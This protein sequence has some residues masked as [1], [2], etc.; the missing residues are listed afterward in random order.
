MLG[1]LNNNLSNLSGRYLWRIFFLSLIAVTLL[2]IIANLWVSWQWLNQPFAGFLQQNQ[3]ITV[4]RLPGWPAWEKGIETGD[5]ILKVE[6]QPLPTPFFSSLD[7]L[8]HHDPSQTVTYLLQKTDGRELEVELGPVLFTMQ[9][10]AQWVFIPTFMALIALTSSG[11]LGYVMPGRPPVTLFGLLTLATIYATISLP[12]LALTQATFYINFF[13]GRIGGILTP[14][15]LLHFLLCYPFTRKKLQTWPFLLPLIYL[16]VLPSFIHLFVLLDQ[17]EAWPTFEKIRTLYTA[18]YLLSGVG[19]LSHAVSVGSS[20]IRKRAIVLLIGLMLPLTLFLLNGLEIL[21]AFTPIYEMAERY[22]LW[23][24]PITVALALFRYDF[25]QKERVSHKHVLFTATLGGLLAICL[26]LF[27]WTGPIPIGFKR[28]QGQDYGFILITVG[29]FYMGRLAF[30][31]FR[32][33]WASRH[34]RYSVEDFR[35]NVRIL[36]RELLKVKSHHELEALISW[37]LATDFSLQSAEISTRN[38]PS[39]P[40]ALRLPLKVNNVSLG[41]LFLGSKINGEPFSKQEQNIFGEA[42]KQI[43]LTLLSLEL[44]EVIQ[45]TEKLT[46]LK[47][48]FLTNVTHELRTPLNGIIN[49]IGFALD[50]AEHLNVEQKSYLHQAVQGAERLLELINNILDMSKIEAGQMTL[51]KHPVNLGE[52]VGEMI[53]VVTELTGDKPIKV[54]TQVSPTLPLI[55]ADRMRVRQILLN[56]LSNAVKFTRSGEIR[57]DIYPGNG[58]VIIKVT[59]TGPGIDETLLPTIFQQFTTNALT[60][61]RE[62]FG[63]GLGLPITKSLVELHQGKINVNSQVNVGT[64]FTVQLPVQET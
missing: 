58:H 54:I 51:L 53:P 13:A 4:S 56:M 3:V 32:H 40:Y 59:D 8:R 52:L 46:R 31:R 2:F 44:G 18:L 19:L 43:S 23:S 7:Y 12:E 37:N 20:P 33:W 15:L 5:I 27:G 17:P 14:P 25:L 41:T 16:P 22:I 50:D 11:V 63:P 24:V 6:A 55:Q 34:L 36:S 21:T 29:L 10:F 35:V 57:L 1:T 60:D 30:Q 45:S 39:S 42:Q 48:K 9:D 28:L 47:S 61:K 49:Y 38:M 62:S 26:L 64:T